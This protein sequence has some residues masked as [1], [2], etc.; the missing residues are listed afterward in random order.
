MFVTIKFHFPGRSVFIKLLPVHLF[1]NL[2]SQFQVTYDQNIY[3]LRVDQDR[4]NWGGES[5]LSCQ[6]QNDCAY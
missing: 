2:S 3:L 5:N 4:Q 1:S 6:L